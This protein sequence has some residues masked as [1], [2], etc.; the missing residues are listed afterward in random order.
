MELIK[1]HLPNWQRP[2]WASVELTETSVK[3]TDSKLESFRIDCALLASIRQNP[4]LVAAN[5]KWA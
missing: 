3:L 2:A 5:L 4:S 1:S